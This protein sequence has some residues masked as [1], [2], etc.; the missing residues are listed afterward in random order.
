MPISLNVM[1][2]DLKT[3]FLKLVNVS[4]YVYITFLKVGSVKRAL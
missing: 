2:I 4:K 1:T 3:T